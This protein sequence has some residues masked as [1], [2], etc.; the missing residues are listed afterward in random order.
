M[1]DTLLRVITVSRERAAGLNAV[2]SLD[3]ASL[4]EHSSP[5]VD[6][7]V[8]RGQSNGTRRWRRPPNLI[9]V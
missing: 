3:R 8:S 2:K 9:S 1:N 7:P 5:D 6:V 4:C